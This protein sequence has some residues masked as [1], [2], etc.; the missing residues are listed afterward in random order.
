MKLDKFFTEEE[1]AFLDNYAK[2]KGVKPNEAILMLAREM[3]QTY[4]LR[5]LSG[6]Q[7]LAMIDMLS[8][9]IPQWLAFQLNMIGQSAMNVNL[10]SKQLASLNQPS[11]LD[12]VMELLKTTDLSKVL[13]GIAPLLAQIGGTQSQERKSDDDMSLDDDQSWL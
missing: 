10:L 5:F 8:M 11:T 2:Q 3:I 13:S 4:N 1:L 7:V 9:K 6:Q 12:K